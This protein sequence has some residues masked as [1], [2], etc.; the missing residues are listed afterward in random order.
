MVLDGD[1]PSITAVVGESGSGKTTL[2][3]LLLGLVTP[4]RGQVLYDGQ[5]LRNMSHADWRAFRHDV[6]VIFQDPYEVYNPFYRVDHVLATPVF[7]FKLASSRVDARALIEDALKAVGLR[8]EETLGRF[9]HQ[10]SGGQRQRV[11]VARALLL[12]PRLI[13]ADEP[14]SMVDASLR[15]TILGSL[16]KMN[17][18]LGISIIYITHDLATAYQISENIVVLYRGS[19]VEAG[20]VELVVKHPQHP[21]TQLL[22]SSV[23]LASTERT[24]T[25]GSVAGPAGI[26]A[27]GSAGCRF[28]GRCPF[29]ASPCLEAAPP[30]FQTDRSR[31]VSCYLYQGAP[32]LSPGEMTKVLAVAGGRGE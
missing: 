15:A 14:V 20:D 1:R 29:A 11:M 24:W 19:V 8:P 18:E 26:Q 25:T 28:V 7:K 21:Y 12:K 17:Q 16:R 2:A 32:A 27:A 3:R 13:L 30:L 4:T 6:Q 9:P 5:D 10:L 22:I 31:A 23:P